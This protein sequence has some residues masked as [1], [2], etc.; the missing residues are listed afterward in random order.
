MAGLGVLMAGLWPNATNGLYTGLDG[1]KYSISIILVPYLITGLTLL[2]PFPASAVYTARSKV[3]IICRKLSLMVST[4]ITAFNTYEYIDL[5]CAEFEQL[6]GEVQNDADEL[7]VLTRLT[8]SEKIVFLNIVHLPE[9]LDRFN[10]TLT[11]LLVALVGL[12]DAL[13]RIVN[14]QTHA[15][16]V[17]HLKGPLDNINEEVEIALC[18][19][20]EHFD[21]FQLVNRG[22]Y[23]WAR[24]TSLYQCFKSVKTRCGWSTPSHHHLAHHLDSLASSGVD[25][26]SR[27]H[28]RV[29]KIY[30]ISHSSELIRTATSRQHR[31][32]ATTVSTEDAH[33]DSDKHS[34]VSRKKFAHYRF[35]A[36]GV[37]LHSGSMHD[38]SEDDSD[39]VVNENMRAEFNRASTMLLRAR[40]NLVH[41]YNQARKIYL[42]DDGQTA[43]SR[44]PEC[45]L[46]EADDLRK[47][48]DMMRDENFRL[49][50]RNLHP[51]SAYIHR[52]SVIVEL[53]V[54]L[55]NTFELSGSFWSP[56][57]CAMICCNT[58]VNYVGATVGDIYSSF[59][60]SVAIV[61]DYD[62]TLSD[63]F[64]HWRSLAFLWL[65]PYAQALKISSAIAIT[66]SFVIFH[67]VEDLATNG[68]W[69][70]FVIAL[71]RQ[72]NTSSSFLVGYQR[73]EGT[74]IGAVF[75]FGLFH[76]YTC[77]ETDQCSH[78]TVVPILIVWLALCALFR[79]GGRHGYAATVASYTPIILFMGH[80]VGIDGVWRRIEQTFL[81]I[82][83]YLIID[84]IVLPVRTYSVIKTSVLQCVNAT[85]VIY[86]ESVAAIDQL[87]KLEKISPTTLESSKS[88]EANSH[89]LSSSGSPTTDRVNDLQSQFRYSRHNTILATEEA[90]DEALSS[91]LAGDGAQDSGDLP[92][93]K[94]SDDLVIDIESQVSC[95]ELV[96]LTPHASQ[97]QVQNLSAEDVVASTEVHLNNAKT[98]L[99]V[100]NANLL[101]QAG[102]MVLV[103][104]EPELWH[105]SFPTLAYNNL[106]ASF[107]NVYRSG[108]AVNSG[109]RELSVIIVQMLERGED[110]SADD[111][112]KLAHDSLKRLYENSEFEADLTA[113]VTLSRYY[114]KLL[115]AVDEQFRDMYATQSAEFLAGLNPYF[116]VAWMNVY[117]STCVLIQHL[118]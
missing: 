13:R 78:W 28:K 22:W 11:E 36:K 108:R 83:I 96:S 103:V 80:N 48:S 99:A 52:L 55:Q 6:L 114:D 106:L 91:V 94:D 64:A 74:V 82:S 101:R 41:G 60:A 1:F 97:A 117:E 24:H 10:A 95:V 46:I 3:I 72:E 27:N 25:D 30:N 116:L 65:K 98:Q 34:S 115:V 7:R 38:P 63:R 110:V 58:T 35:S 68:L 40:G 113:I 56:V 112:L 104:H 57:D 62:R 50:G 107:Q 87:V 61:K 2:F 75:S 37:D 92:T 8:K 33:E 79:E 54:S 31:P 67:K 59:T 73:L 26:T 51:R 29:K 18:I 20:S 44:S 15:T 111:A 76:I 102:Q 84:N 53:V 47:M 109:C 71:I 4:L 9:A 86:S 42:F 17:T 105:R 89:D 81:G 100:L 43:T 69:S 12:K 16:F 88:G 66:A 49:G 45:P 5:C 19:V 14:N 70:S 21:T 32:S 90:V 93:P 23:I 118:S 39:V 77:T 85:R